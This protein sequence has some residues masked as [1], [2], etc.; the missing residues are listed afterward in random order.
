MI[1]R[2]TNAGGYMALLTPGK[3]K[4]KEFVNLRFPSS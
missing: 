1:I 2:K 4:I 3:L